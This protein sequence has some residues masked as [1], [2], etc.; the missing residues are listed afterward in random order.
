MS[1]FE[2][3][4]ETGEATSD[5]GEEF[6]GAVASEEESSSQDSTPAQDDRE[7]DGLAALLAT[8]GIP[9]A[10][11]GSR[12]LP[13]PLV[14]KK[15]KKAAEAVSVAQKEPSAGSFSP[16]LA[17]QFRQWKEAQLAAFC[18]LVGIW[19]GGGAG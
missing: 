10:R 12:A 2:G 13:K 5:S 16:E 15:T 3:P 8:K 14:S 7:E 4:V 17:E 18:A 1:D 11:D 6:D 19:A 9:D